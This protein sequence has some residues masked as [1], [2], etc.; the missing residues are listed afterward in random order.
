[1]NR[2]RLKPSPALVL[3]S[4]ALLLALTGAA[5]AGPQVFSKKGVTKSK[6]KSISKRQANAQITA[7]APGLSVANSRT[8][9]SAN[10]TAFA[11]V[12]ADGT[13]N[14]ATSKGVTQANVINAGPI[15]GYYCFG[16]LPFVPRGGNATVDWNAGSI[17]TFAL[18]GLG[19][20]PSCP[21]GTQLFVDTRLPDFTGSKPAGFFLTLYR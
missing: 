6:V 8:A 7:R 16:N 15:T 10:P 21:A 1:M 5:V 11:Q 2:P 3:A 4:I 12:A 19:G 13:V 14:A 17:D 18:I 20:N 9:D